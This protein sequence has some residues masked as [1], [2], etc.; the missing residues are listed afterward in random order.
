MFVDRDDID[1]TGLNSINDVPQRLPSSGG[2]NAK[3]NN[4]G[5]LGNPAG[6]FPNTSRSRRSTSTEK[7]PG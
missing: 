3:C 2:L 6:D 4:S 5:N 1:K 7:V